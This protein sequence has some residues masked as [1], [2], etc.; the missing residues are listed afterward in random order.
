MDS[1]DSFDREFKEFRDEKQRKRATY[2]IIGIIAVLIFASLIFLLSGGVKSSTTITTTSTTSESVST[3]TIRPNITVNYTIIQM[4]TNFS[5]FSQ[6]AEGY[7][8][9]PNWID[10]LYNRV[11]SYLIP[12]VSEQ[13]RVYNSSQ[14]VPEGKIALPGNVVYTAWASFASTNS[15]NESLTLS[16]IDFLD[17]NMSYQTYIALSNY[18]SAAGSS[19]IR[20]LTVLQNLPPN[21]S[22]AII[23][24][25]NQSCLFNRYQPYVCSYGYIIGL[26]KT[27]VLIAYLIQTNNTSINDQNPYLQAIENF[28]NTQK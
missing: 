18:T 17:I 27:N 10:Y 1:E 11:P 16:R 28:V 23:I 25:S 3:T 7:L 14:H 2:I 26:N 12:Y 6:E 21:M 8:S 15:S 20:E 22:G 24:P 13:L 9:G 5:N 4:P 19:G